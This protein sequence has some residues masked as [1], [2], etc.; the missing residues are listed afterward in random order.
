MVGLGATPPDSSLAASLPFVVYK[1]YG[2]YSF[3]PR[4]GGQPVTLVLS[5]GYSVANWFNGARLVVGSRVA[6]SIEQAIHHGFAR[7]VV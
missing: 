7:V 2:H 1:L 6:V 4:D 3:N 5:D